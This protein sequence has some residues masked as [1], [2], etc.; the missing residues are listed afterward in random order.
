MRRREKMTTILNNALASSMIPDGVGMKPARTVTAD[1]AAA[2]LRQGFT[3]AGNP[4]H[5]NTWQAAAKLLAIEE[6][7]DPKGGRVVLAAGD[8]LLVAE[9]SGL[10]RATREFSDEEI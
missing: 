2:L 8:V 6:V 7:G 9:I 3:H 4:G 1:E 10:P 5:A